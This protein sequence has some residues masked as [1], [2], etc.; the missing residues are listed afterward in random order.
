M[1]SGKYYAL[2]RS[3]EIEAT[4]QKIAEDFDRGRPGLISG[5]R[6]PKIAAPFFGLAK[7]KFGRPIFR[8]L[9]KTVLWREGTRDHGGLR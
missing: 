8:D 6:D 7:P 3:C 5:S 2:K 9:S 4:Y 1:N